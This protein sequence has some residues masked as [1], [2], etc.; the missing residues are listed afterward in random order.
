MN[1]LALKIKEERIKAGLTE[2]DLAKKCGL[3]ISYILQV[4]SGKKIIN[5]KIADNILKALG[6]KEEFINEDRVIKEPKNKKTVSPKQEK[7]V[8]EPNLAWSSALAGVIEKYPIYEQGSKKILGYKELPIINK[9]VEGHKPDKLSFVKSTSNDLKYFR[10]EKND[11]VTLIKSTDIQNYG[12]YVITYKGRQLFRQLVIDSNN[13]IK[14]QKTSGATEFITVN[15]KDLKVEGRIIK[16]EF[17]I[18]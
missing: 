4:E 11:I 8:V 14:L 7:I 13:K 18:K 6:T 17:S 5:E 12:L 2:K 15:K 3:S 1:R 10:I 9:K 16:V